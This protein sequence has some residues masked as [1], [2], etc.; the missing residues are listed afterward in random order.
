MESATSLLNALF[1]DDKRYDLSKVGRFKFNKKL[2]LSRRIR[3][4][5]AARDI[6]DPETGEIYAKKG[7]I[8]GIDASK[9]IEKSGVN[10]VYLMFEGKEIKVFSNGMVHLADHVDFDVSDLGITEKVRYSVLSEILDSKESEL[11]SLFPSTSFLTIF[12][13]RLTITT[14]FH[15]VWAQPTTSTIS[16]TE[17]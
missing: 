7:E 10:V 8:I 5:E 3:N 14:T 15:T 2:A 6:V 9:E 1:Y 13:R 4:F 12:W 17:E 16:E 11:M